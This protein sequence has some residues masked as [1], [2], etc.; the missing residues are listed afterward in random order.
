MHLATA[1]T[2]GKI[3]IGSAINKMVMSASESVTDSE[4]GHRSEASMMQSQLDICR[5]AWLAKPPSITERLTDLGKL[6]QQLGQYTDKL[7]SAISEDFG[8][9]PFAESM[10][11]DVLQVQSEIKYTKAHLKAWCKRQHQTVDWKYW[12]AQAWLQYQPLGVIGIVSPWNYPLTLTLMPMVSALAAGNH[13]MLKPSEYTPATNQ[14][15]KALIADVFPPEKVTVVTGAAAVSAAFSSLPFDHLL[16]TG[17]TQIGKKVMAAAAQNLTPVTLEL[18]GKSPAIVASSKN[19]ERSVASIVT[20]KLFNAG[21]TCIAPDYVLVPK[22]MLEPFVTAAKTAAGRAYP[23]FNTNDEYTSIIH[24]AHYQR[25]LDMLAE[26]VRR[27]VKF[28]P[29]F[30]VPHDAQRRRVTPTLVLNPAVELGLMQE[31]IFGPILPVLEVDDFSAAIKFIKNRARPLSLYIF[32]A[33]RV[34]HEQLLNEVRVGGVC[35]NDTLLHMTQLQLP[36]GGVGD[37]GMGQYHGWYGFE[38]FSKAQPVYRQS[39]LSGSKM[40]RPPFG[41]WKRKVMRWLGG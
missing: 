39:R 13:V 3:Q 6:Q 26:A 40:F 14:V 27:G 30:E 28:E 15:L 11:G 33:D 32:G 17:S 21:Q 29:L 23:G 16:F 2:A 5:S 1:E 35:I 25:L 37:S 36:F 24:Q 20:G 19:F 12:P 22:G 31:E 8:H 38:R 41:P 7:I 18:G 4:T 34:Q 9:R 10:L